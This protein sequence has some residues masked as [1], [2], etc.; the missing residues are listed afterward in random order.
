MVV[1]QSEDGQFGLVVDGINDTQ[2]IVV[3]PLGKQLKGLTWYAGA[4]T[5]GDGRVALIL[6]VH[7][8][9]ERAGVFGG[10]HERTHAA[11][12]QAAKEKGQKVQVE[13]EQQRLLLFQ[14]GSFKTL[15]PSPFSRCPARGVSAV[16]Y[17]TCEWR[18]GHSISG[19]HPYLGVSAGCAG[20]GAP[21]P[22]RALDPVPVVVFN[23]GEHSVGMICRRDRRC[24]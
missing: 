1:L 10:S 15:G 6:D 14:A 24:C 8:I 3:K 20:A 9:G 5:M 23:E 19:Q 17:R 4:T 18:A 16:G 22:D 13:I 7:G 12:E 21:E 2:E 11:E